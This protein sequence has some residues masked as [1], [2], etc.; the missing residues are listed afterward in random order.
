MNYS[1]ISSEQISDGTVN[2]N[3]VSIVHA[4]MEDGSVGWAAGPHGCDSCAVGDR[5]EFVGH[6]LPSREAA[7]DDAES[8]IDEIADYAVPCPVCGGE[9]HL[10][11]V[12]RNLGHYPC[13]NIRSNCT[14]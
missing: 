3:P 10:L 14:T 11:G 7:L 4:R 2:D 8:Q 12:L 13:R 9:A 5:L 6:L 1:I